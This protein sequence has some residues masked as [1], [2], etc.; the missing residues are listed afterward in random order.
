MLT[1][2]IIAINAFMGIYTHEHLYNLLYGYTTFTAMYFFL[3]TTPP[4]HVRRLVGLNVV[5]LAYLLLEYSIMLVSEMI[6]TLR[7]RG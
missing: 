2:I 5:S 6:D 3:A 7:S 1:L 4:Q